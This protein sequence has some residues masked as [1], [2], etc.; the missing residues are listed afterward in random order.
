MVHFN[1][2]YKFHTSNFAIIAIHFAFF[3]FKMSVYIFMTVYFFNAVSP[4]NYKPK[5]NIFI[6]LNLNILLLC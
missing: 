1:L 5:T 3:I 4:Q 6:L 2:S